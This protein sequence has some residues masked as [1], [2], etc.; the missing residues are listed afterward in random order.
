MMKFAA[1]RPWFFVVEDFYCQHR[2]IS[3]TPAAAIARFPYYNRH[4]PVTDPAAQHPDFFE[5]R[6]ANLPIGL[7]FG[8]FLLSNILYKIEKNAIEKGTYYLFIYL[9]AR[10]P[11][12]A[13]LKIL[14]LFCCLIRLL[15]STHSINF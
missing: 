10:R 4:R 14:A 9:K 11:S 7:E 13:I 1:I 3:T 15:L 8:L 2:V 6:A 5:K 12:P